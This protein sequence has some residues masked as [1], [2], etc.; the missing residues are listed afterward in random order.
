MAV[1][2][3]DALAADFSNRPSHLADPVLVKSGPMTIAWIMSPP[4]ANS[5]GHQNLLRFIKFAE[6]AGHTN[7]IYFYTSTPVVVSEKGMRQMFRESGAYPEIAASMEMYDREKGVDPS[8]QALFA[9]GWET[10]YPVFLDPSRAKRFYFVQDFEPSFYPVGSESILAENT[11]RFGFHGLTAGG[12]L[13]HKLSNEYGM[14]TDHFDFGV[15]RS[16]YNV[17]NTNHRTEIFFYARPT[18]AR[19][20][21]ELGVMAL[22]EF[23]RRKPEIT[24][25]LAGYDVSRWSLR[26]PHNNL[27]GVGVLQLNELYNRCAAGL[28]ISAS[29]MSLLPLELMASGVAP[30]VNDAPNNRMVSDNP[31]IEYVLPAPGSLAQRLVD[32]VERTDAPQ[33]ATAMSASLEG[34][35]WERS[36]EQFVSAF[37]A[38]MRG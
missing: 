15:D 8:V 37:E 3:E 22:A 11:Y 13:A 25:N 2:T 36:G 18:T 12:W 38:A 32:V 10:A 5:G 29:N 33:R 26:F 6:N 35:T 27:A 1:K 7:K 31:Y 14:P 24:I 17:T 34:L 30:V 21:F 20:G 16:N 28:V 4:S 19:R 9:T 23:A